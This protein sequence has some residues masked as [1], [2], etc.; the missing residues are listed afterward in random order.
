MNVAIMTELSAR[1]IGEL[2]HWF[3]I[4]KWQTVIMLQRSCWLMEEM[5]LKII[6]LLSF[7]EV[8]KIYG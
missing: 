8:L 2:L 6:V 3:Q 1:V 7:A 5:K 4:P